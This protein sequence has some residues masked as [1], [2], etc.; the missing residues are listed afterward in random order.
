MR[1]QADQRGQA[2]KAVPTI[3]VSAILS[4]I[5]EIRAKEGSHSQVSTTDLERTFASHSIMALRP[6]TVQQSQPNMLNPA[7]ILDVQ[8]IAAT[9]AS[10]TQPSYNQPQNSLSAQDPKLQN[11]LAQIAQLNPA[12]GRE[13]AHQSRGQQD[14][15]WGGGDN[16]RRDWGRG[17]RDNHH[18]GG[19][20][21][22]RGRSRGYHSGGDYDRRSDY[23]NGNSRD[24]GRM[25]NEGDDRKGS[26][27]GRK[28][29]S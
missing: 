27:D 7:Q 15:S 23:K 5:A 12:F 8:R 3:D 17:Q 2:D 14:S 11:V 25:R 16:D 18:G 21:E 10:T 20:D 4:G 6:Q 9:L 19:D 1:G 22:W 29:V 24:Y 28:N 26:F 13:P